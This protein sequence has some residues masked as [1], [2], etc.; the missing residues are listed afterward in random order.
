MV[1]TPSVATMSPSF[2]APIDD[3]SL[4][5]DDNS[6][7]SSDESVLVQVLVIEHCRTVAIKKVVAARRTRQNA[8]HRR[9]KHIR[10]KRV[11][12]ESVYLQLG[13]EGFRRAYR[14]SYGSFRVLTDWLTPGIVAS[15]RHA[16]TGQAIA[17]NTSRTAPNG[18][19]GASVRLA[20]ALRYL[21]GGSV[22]DIATTFCIAIRSVY[23][24]IWAVI[25]AISNYEPMDFSFPSSHDKQKA[26]ALGFKEVSTAGFDCCVGAIDGILIWIERPS[27]K[28]AAESK[29]GV[30]KYFSGR[31][32]KFGLNVQ[33]VCD[34]KCR[35]IDMCSRSG[36]STADCVAFAESEL[37]VRLHREGVAAPGLC[38]FGDNAYINQLYMATPFPNVATSAKVDEVSRQRDAYNFYHS[39]VRIKIECAFGMLINRWALLR[40]A[41]PAT[42]HI[43]KVARIVGCA[44]KLHNFCIDRREMEVA[45]SASQDQQRL[46][47]RK[48]V[49]VEELLGTE[50]FGNNVPRRSELR[51][52]RTQESN[53]PR[54]R[55]LQVIIDK[56]LHRPNALTYEQQQ[57]Q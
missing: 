38:L 54:T 29:V 11:P 32:G 27:M 48:G 37:Y 24:S 8:K 55:L 3:S 2:L 35:F 36:G 6:M 1:A 15:L 13:A 57:H 10:R 30:Q 9:Q 43:R 18:V 56:D 12:V 31:K 45:E 14:M 49:T 34:A 26:I 7:Y 23:T 4:D 20:C 5:N 51:R 21:A 46:Y 41:I 33:A 50:Y 16:T 17:P 44:M 22:Y 40:T 53:L 39:Q 42:T 47:K 25:D 19:I 52:E 28:T